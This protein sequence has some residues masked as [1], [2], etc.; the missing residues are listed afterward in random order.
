MSTRRMLVKSGLIVACIAAILEGTT[1]LGQGK[2]TA[3][4]TLE[5]SVHE[6]PGAQTYEQLGQ[7]FGRRHQNACA[8][9]AFKSAVTFDPH[10]ARLSYLLGT[11]LFFSGRLQEAI[12]ALEQSVKIE[13]NVLEPHLLLASALDKAGRDA[14][15]QSQW[16]AALQ[17]DP[18]SAVAL[19][20]LSKSMVASGQYD[21]AIRMLQSQL[22]GTAHDQDETLTID[23]AYAYEKAGRLEDAGAILEPALSAHPSSLPLTDALVTLLIHETK[24][25][26]AT[27]LA[28]KALQ[29][30]PGKMAAQRIY[31]RVLMLKGNSPEALQLGHTLL[32]EAPHDPELLYLNGDMERR[33]RDYEHARTHLQEAVALDP[34]NANTRAALGT[35]LARLQDDNGARLQLEKALALGAQDPQVHYE[36]SR[37]LHD[38]GETSQAQEQ[39]QIFQQQLQAH[40]LATRAASA[41]DQADHQ[42]SL[43]DPKAAIALYQQ[44]LEATPKDALLEYKLALALDSTG[45]AAGEDAALEHAVQIDPTLALAQYRL[46]YLA[47]QNGDQA[48]AEAQFRL[49]VHDAPE[50]TQ[51][52]MSLA[53]TL[54]AESRFPEAKEAIDKALQLDPHNAEAQQ[55]NEMIKTAQAGH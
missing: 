16:K 13:P 28:K 25:E 6:H 55:L 14:D 10:S 22:A 46:G 3:P 36:L 45:D 23:L 18:H 34:D 7:W 24:F 48:K 42:M 11:S 50:F 41:A 29:S 37:V 20:G 38:L 8:V 47:S 33:Y 19:D 15:A 27:E 1:A 26:T 39:L 32:G 51:A 35:V 52:W 5:S 49:A 21:D 40:G 53:A 2:C 30:H 17:L 9:D 31:L 44:A 4:P 43:G 12:D 54:G